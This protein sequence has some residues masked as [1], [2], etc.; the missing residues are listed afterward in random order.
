MLIPG[1]QM[2]LWI[3]AIG[4]GLSMGPIWPAAFTLAG[5]SFPLTGK[6]SSIVLLGDSSGTMV[7]PW[8]VGRVIETNGPPA[9]LVLVFGSL[10]LSLVTFLSMLYLRAKRSGVHVPN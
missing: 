6:I 7:L 2:I 3:M 9:M 5:Q 10:F 1:S 4:L 8:L